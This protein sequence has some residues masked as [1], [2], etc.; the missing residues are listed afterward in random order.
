MDK[1]ENILYERDYPRASDDFFVKYF[2]NILS[3]GYIYKQ[4]YVDKG[5]D[6]NGVI[7]NDYTNTDPDDQQYDDTFV[8][9][10]M[11]GRPSMFTVRWMD[12]YSIFR[13]MILKSILKLKRTSKRARHNANMPDTCAFKTAA[14]RFKYAQHKHQRLS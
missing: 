1:N 2:L 13:L 12:K 8:E 4:K 6:R 10:T 14:E 11:E 9:Q 7:L 3:A 5:D